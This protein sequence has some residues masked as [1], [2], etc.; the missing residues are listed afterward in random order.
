MDNNNEY[1]RNVDTSSGFP[2]YG[3]LPKMDDYSNMSSYE[4]S[5]NMDL[6]G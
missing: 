1:K 4:S 3:D 6:G 5:V 2:S